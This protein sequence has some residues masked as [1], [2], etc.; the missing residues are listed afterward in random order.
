MSKLKVKTRKSPQIFHISI[1]H[2]HSKL[3]KVHEKVTPQVKGLFLAARL[4]KVHEKITKSCHNFFVGSY[5]KFTTKSQQVFS[6]YFLPARFLKVHNKA[7]KSCQYL[8]LVVVVVTSYWKFTTKVTAKVNTITNCQYSFLTG[9][10]TAQESQLKLSV[11]IP[12]LAGSYSK[13]T[14]SSLQFN[15][16]IIPRYNSIPIRIHKNLLCLSKKMFRLQLIRWVAKSNNLEQ[17]AK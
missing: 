8:L 10:S 11:L 17:K 6:I 13:F 3:S 16:K 14:R 15:T 4:L 7:Y 1:S 12:R 5:W 2:T 9:H